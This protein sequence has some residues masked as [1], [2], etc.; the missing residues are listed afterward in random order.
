MNLFGT[1][2]I[3]ENNL[4]VGEINTIELAKRFGTPLYVMD[5]EQIRENCRRFRK[6]MKSKGNNNKV[7]YAGKAFLTK[8][9]VQI[10]KDEELCL[11]V[12]SGGEVYTAIVSEFP[13]ERAYFHG[14]NKTIEEIKLGIKAGVG[15]FV[16]DNMM[17]LENINNIC[18]AYG[19]KQ[20]ILLRII[21]G[22][23]AHT[24]EYIKTGQI[25]SKFG[26]TLL[27]NNIFGVVKAIGEFE[28]I[29]LKGLH[30]H[31]GSQIFDIEPYKEAVRVMMNLMNSINNNFQVNM[32]EL[33]LGGGFGIYYGEGDD[34]KTIEEYC[35]GIL[36]EVEICS[37][38]LQIKNPNIIIE[39]GRSVVGNSGITLYTIGGVKEIPNIKR[40]VSVDGGMTDNIRPSLYSAQYQGLIANNVENNEE[41]LVTVS[42]KCCESGDVLIND[43]SL[44]MVRKGDIFA[45]LSTG[46]YCYSMSSNYNKIPKAPVVLVGKLGPRLICKR[47]TYED[48]L[49]NELDLEI[50]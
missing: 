18:E 43:I 3:R 42:G 33:N 37:S 12:V 4:F 50:I 13:M 27:A 17:E 14:N 40:Y 34:P 24:H 38:K 39:P 16:V 30:C 35:D 23:E 15:T 11:D 46:A 7:A 21:P 31:I 2:N 25:D 8:A 36:N 47:E 45:V 32:T 20:D 6:A 28:N 48:M 41:A 26:F 9:I 29:N 5:E 19:K 49:R 22:I 10:I 1:M 44:P